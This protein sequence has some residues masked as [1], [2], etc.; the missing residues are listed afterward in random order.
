MIVVELVSAR[1]ISQAVGSIERFGF[2]GFIFFDPSSFM[3]LETGCAVLGDC[4]TEEKIKFQKNVNDENENK[5][6]LLDYQNM[7]YE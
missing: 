5:H 7:N 3:V 2:G 6:V 1:K 4:K